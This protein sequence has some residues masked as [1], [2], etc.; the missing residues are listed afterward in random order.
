[1]E[2]VGKDGLVGVAY[3]FGRRRQNDELWGHL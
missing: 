3:E 2:G 1:M